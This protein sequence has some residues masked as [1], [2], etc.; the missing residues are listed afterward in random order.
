MASVFNWARFTGNR[1]ML[2]GLGVLVI[3]QLFFNY[4]E[5]IQALLGVAASDFAKTCVRHN[6]HELKLAPSLSCRSEVVPLIR[7]T[8][9]GVIF[10]VNHAAIN[11]MMVS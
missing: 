6:N 2:V 10:P 11:G 8:C 5:P 7:T 9:L 4:Q 1:Y 3:F